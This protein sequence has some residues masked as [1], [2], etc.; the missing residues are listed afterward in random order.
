MTT[1]F[2]DLHKQLV[3]QTLKHDPSK[4]HYSPVPYYP[5]RSGSG[6]VSKSFSFGICAPGL[7]SQKCFFEVHGIE[8]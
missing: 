8:L 7:I 6:L 3:S 1:I 2:S 4:N 5:E